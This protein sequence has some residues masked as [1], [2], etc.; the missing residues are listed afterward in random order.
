MEIENNIENNNN[1]NNDIGDKQNNFLQT[2]IGKIV[3]TAIN[4]GLRF[5]LP[6]I[7]ENQ[8]IKIKDAIIEEGFKE[9][10]SSAVKEGIDL[11][12]STIGIVTG[13]FDNISQMQDAIKSGGII[14]NVSELIDYAVDKGNEKGKISTQQASLI[15]K[16]KNVI[17]DNIN[18]N[19][20]SMMSDQVNLIENLEKYCESWQDNF[21]DKNLNGMETYIK[22]IN[23]TI[24][25]IAPIEN[26]INNSKKIINIHNLIKNNG[27]NF[28]I[29]EVEEQL[30]EM[31]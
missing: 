17:L 31:L 12:K 8:V 1:L 19:I 27:N 30:A 21:K 24:N 9:G 22:K 7:V 2:N 28:E 11:G 6:D 10:I 20:E 16:G 4:V 25:K 29:S 23:N 3:N 5:V 14:D 26:L 18:S 15:K 13:K